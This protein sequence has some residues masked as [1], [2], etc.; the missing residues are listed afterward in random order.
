MSKLI[1]PAFTLQN[2]EGEVVKQD[3]VTL[4]LNSE[5]RALLGELKRLFNE[6][7]DGTAIKK[8]L[9]ISLHVVKNNFGD[10]IMHYFT[11]SKR[12]RTGTQ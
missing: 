3:V 1:K 10:K 11:Q 2:L 8:C 12:E 5:E 9:E 6:R 7:K 4:R